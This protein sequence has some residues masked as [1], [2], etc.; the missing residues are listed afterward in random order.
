MICALSSP[1]AVGRKSTRGSCRPAAVARARAGADMRRGQARLANAGRAGLDAVGGRIGARADDRAQARAAEV[2]RDAVFGGEAG[3]HT[4]LDEAV[5]LLAPDGLGVVV[6]A[7]GIRQQP[8]SAYRA[9][10]AMKCAE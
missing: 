5:I 2:Q 6:D 4:V 1:E 10:G 3:A 8:Q 9:G 7:V